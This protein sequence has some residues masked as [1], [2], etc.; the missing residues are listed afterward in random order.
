[1]EADSTRLSSM[2][3]VLV[4]NGNP[5][6]QLLLALLLEGKGLDLHQAVDSTEA[7]SALLAGNFGALVV[8]CRLTPLDGIA[9][10]AWCRSQ[11]LHLPVILLADD[12]RAIPAAAAAL[13]DCCATLL[14]KPI[15]QTQLCEALAA[16]AALAHHPGCLH[17]ASTLEMTPFR[18]T[19]MPAGDGGT[20]PV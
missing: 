14:R 4:A 19:L 11:S 1:M 16:A 3:N 18:D 5:D 17:E 9:L 20:G 10:L 2:A 13:G 6:E 7:M 12:K 8:D 15:S